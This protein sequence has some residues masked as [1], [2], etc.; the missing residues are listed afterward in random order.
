MSDAP[1]TDPQIV[2]DDPDSTPAWFDPDIPAF[3]RDYNDDDQQLAK[4]M[5]PASAEPEVD[6]DEPLPDETQG[7]PDADPPPTDDETAPQ[8]VAVE[9]S[10]GT[11]DI[12]PTPPTAVAAESPYI[13]IGG[14]QFPRERAEE[15][16][17]LIDLGIAKVQETPLIPTAPQPAAPTGPDVPDFNPDNYVDPEMARATIAQIEAIKQAQAPLQEQLGQLLAAQQRREQ[18]EEQARLAD[19]NTQEGVAVATV[20]AKFGLSDA[21]M[22]ELYGLTQQSGIVN[23]MMIQNPAAAANFQ[24]I[25]ETALE[26]NYWANEK[27]RTRQIETQVAT[28]VADQVQTQQVHAKKSRAGSLVG[29]GGTVSREPTP[30]PRSNGAPRDPMAEALEA[31]QEEVV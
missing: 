1:T 11:N 10:G 28:Q 30:K 17:Q 20:K 14:R 5:R 31:V 2:E 8:P 7:E 26:T 6:P 24:Q 13:V 25:A 16:L 12:P 29:G 3:A 23:G 27:F 15:I 9:G 4:L 18:A 19:L 22:N 21:E